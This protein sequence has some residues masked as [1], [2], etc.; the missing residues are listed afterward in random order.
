MTEGAEPITRSK[1]LVYRTTDGEL[2][3]FPYEERGG[4]ARHW[5]DDVGEIV[6]QLGPGDFVYVPADR[7][8]WAVGP[9]TGVHAD[10][11]VDVRFL[12]ESVKRDPRRMLR[13]AR[14]PRME[15]H[16]PRRDAFSFSNG[17]ERE[18]ARQL[19]ERMERS[20]DAAA[21]GRS[22][23][24]LAWSLEALAVLS[25]WG[26]ALVDTAVRTGTD[27]D[28]TRSFFRNSRLQE[29]RRAIE[30]RVRDLASRV[31]E[32][33]RAPV[34]TAAREAPPLSSRL[35]DGAFL[36]AALVLVLVSGLLAS[37]LAGV[38]LDRSALQPER[39][40]RIDGWSVLGLL[41]I[42][43][44]LGGVRAL[45]GVGTGWLAAYGAGFAAIGGGLAHYLALPFFPK[46]PYSLALL[47]GFDAML[48][49]ALAVGCETA[50]RF[51]EEF[52]R[53]SAPL[54][55]GFPVL[56]GLAGLLDPGSGSV[57]PTELFALGA[58]IGTAL[59]VR[60]P[61]ALSP[62]ALRD[63]EAAPAGRSRT[64]RSVFGL[65]VLSVLGGSILSVKVGWIAAALAAIAA[66]GPLAHARSVGSAVGL[67]VP[68]A[69]AALFFAG[70][71]DAG[72]AAWTALALL[73]LPFA[74]ADALWPRFLSSLADGLRAA[75]RP[76]LA[77]PVLD[78][79]CGTDASLI[80]PRPWL[81][82]AADVCRELDDLPAA[83]FHLERAGEHVRA[84]EVYLDAAR[85]MPP[86]LSTTFRPRPA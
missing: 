9:I 22:Q 80:V 19:Q 25:L 78:A 2:S 58:M 7:A 36:F 72:A 32:R 24:A 64:A 50:T 13:L 52:L 35:R 6:E 81:V 61:R 38:D 39:F 77:R 74:L 65:A 86:P 16:T 4:A 68:F 66:A 18:C 76:R 48:V 3:A 45:R 31:E 67:G 69:L 17:S 79:L 1:V 56:L 42:G 11:S 63:E 15:F 44:A 28:S 59:A 75:G 37:V 21:H 8:P 60:W 70:S 49:T 12:G 20:A 47:L 62:A 27:A 34:A 30:E 83:A 40:D 29:R 54:L 23:E 14:P 55:I 85:R 46:Q 51:R 71:R 84:G 73:C 5:P 82:A 57:R 43:L 53:P 26:E 41:G 33:R 10:G